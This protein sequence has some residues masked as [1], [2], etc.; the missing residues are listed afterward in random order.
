MS[1]LNQPF[2]KLAQHI[3]CN[4][5]TAIKIQGLECG[6]FTTCHP[7]KC[8]SCVNMDNYLRVIPGLGHC[9]SYHLAG[10]H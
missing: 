5:I 7:L 9:H 4:I 10:Q 2:Q 1:T 8:S 3:L 6:T